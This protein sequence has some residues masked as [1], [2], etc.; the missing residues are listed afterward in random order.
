MPVITD[1]ARIGRRRGRVSLHVDGAFFVQVPADLADRLQLR[2]GD[3][4]SDAELQRIR[5]QAA[6]TDAVDA[7][8][9]YL[10]YRPR[11]R[12]ELERRLRRRGCQPRH[13]AT[14]VERCV[15]L[16]YV[17][18]RAFAL[19]FV[20]ERVR[21]RPRG[22]ARLVSELLQRGVDR[23]V[24]EGAV[25]DA[26]AEEGVR[27]SDLLRAAAAKRWRA[28][29]DL[30]PG[31]ARRRLSAYLARRGFPHAGIRTVVGELVGHD[32]RGMAGSG[33]D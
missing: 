30:D 21:F 3:A 2:V 16:G 1:L 27:E 7:A 11:S 29:R 23:D 6:R 9:H 26:M 32:E 14:A 13:V 5:E 8:L 18:D 17:D 4:L 22:R 33:D 19:A 31:T 12:V 10:S 20:R 15:E 24:A 28:V 25:R